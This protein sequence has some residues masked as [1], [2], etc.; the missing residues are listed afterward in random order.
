M[1]GLG[2]GFFLGSV[3]QRR[4]RKFSLCLSNIQLP[5]ALSFIPILR[6]KVAGLVSVACKYSSF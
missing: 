1:V 4:G 6:Q 3:S 2:I 5:A